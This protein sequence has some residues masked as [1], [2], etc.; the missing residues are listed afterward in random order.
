MTKILT[1]LFAAMM[2]LAIGAP[3]LA[4]S[5][6]SQGQSTQATSQ[7]MQA[8]AQNDA[9]IF[10]GRITDMKTIQF[11][12]GQRYVLAKIKDQQGHTAVINL[13]TAQALG[14][15]NAQ[16]RNG[17][18]IVALGRGGRL[19]GKPILVVYS[20]HVVPANAGTQISR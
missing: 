7:S 8:Q 15:R 20:F 17:E 18:Q 11:N 3:A 9:G 10:R 5:D 16:L 12:N 13:G 14:Q 1:P 19:N 4:Q 2:A 6:Q